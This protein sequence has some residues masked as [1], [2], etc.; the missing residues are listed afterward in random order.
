MS[1]ELQQI[2]ITYVPLV[3]VAIMLAIGFIRLYR[4]RKNGIRRDGSTYGMVI[5][6]LLATPVAHAL[7][8]PVTACMAGAMILGFVIGMFVKYERKMDNNDDYNDEN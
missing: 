2:L 5:G 1:E 7:N 6:I 4:L 3:I 8:L